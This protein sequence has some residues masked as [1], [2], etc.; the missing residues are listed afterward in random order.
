[1][2]SK[3]RLWIF[4]VIAIGAII[5]I[6]FLAAPANNQ[7]QSG[8]TY[9]RDP[10]GY[11]AWYAFMLERG[12]PIQ[13]WQ[14]PFQDLVD[15]EAK[16]PITLL[17]VYSQLEAPIS[18]KEREWVDK[19]N[20]LV[21]LGIRHPVTEAAFSTRHNSP[22]GIIKIDTRRRKIDAEGLLSDR[23]GAIVWKE[24]IG[25]GKVVYATT[26]HL[27]ANAYQDFKSNYEFLAQIVTES[28]ETKKLSIPNQLLVDE[29]LHGYKDAEVIKREQGENIIIYFT[30]TPLFPALIPAFILLLVAIWAGNRRFGQ[31]LTLS[32]P[33]IDNSVAYIQALAG[34]LQKANSTEFVVEVVGKEE[35]LQLQKALGLGQVPLDHQSLIDAWVQQTGHPATELESLLNSHSRKSKMSEL[36]LLAWLE[37]WEQIRRHLPS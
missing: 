18:K 35:Q 7:Q 10:A 20:T 23:F 1:M 36:K 37:K 3:R 5:L 27:A 30:K 13:R 17:R 34:V 14:K 24:S 16:P 21:L 22:Q 2:K 8:S 9:A 4:G 11:G 12:S 26:P 33:V 25:K 6:T 32:A 31:P 29:Y 15:S 28:G 19:G